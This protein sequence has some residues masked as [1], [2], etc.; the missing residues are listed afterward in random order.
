[1]FAFG[2]PLCGSSVELE[3]LTGQILHLLV[4]QVEEPLWG[5]GTVS[6][7]FIP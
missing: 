6:H 4:E 3:L 5:C 7:A 1:M 2:I